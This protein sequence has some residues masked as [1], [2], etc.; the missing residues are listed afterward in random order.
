MNTAVINSI[1][2]GKRI[3]IR[4]LVQGV[5]F[6][7]T[8]WQLAHQYKLV[9]QVLNDGDGVLINAFGSAEDLTQFI[10]ALPHHSPPLARIDHIESLDINSQ[11]H[12]CFSI[13]KS[14]TTKSHTGI[15]AD[16]ATCS[17]C[18]KEILEPS[19]RRF[20]YPFTNC[21]HCGPRL[22]II[23]A[24][25]YDRKNTSMSTFTLCKSAK[26]NMTTQRIDAFMHNRMLV[27]SVVLNSGLNPL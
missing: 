12:N 25:P 5:G 13:A 1:H 17:A 3:R 14:Q 7:P 22:S 23:K 20:G 21:T 15:V 16:A 2:L 4:G 26:V 9:G 10:D 24:V 6:R 18:A 19:N 11:D 8:V 27:L